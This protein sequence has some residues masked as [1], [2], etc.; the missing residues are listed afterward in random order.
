MNSSG[1]FRARWVDIA[2]GFAILSVVLLHNINFMTASI[3]HY[4]HY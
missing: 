3:C 2:K 1:L 4:Q